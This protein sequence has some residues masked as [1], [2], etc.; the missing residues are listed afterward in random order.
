MALAIDFVRKM[1]GLTIKT[2]SYNMMALMCARL[3]PLMPRSVLATCNA[4][5]K[6]RGEATETYVH[7][8]LF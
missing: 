2:A 8:L 7:V 6:A 1:T 3:L 4:L 5:T